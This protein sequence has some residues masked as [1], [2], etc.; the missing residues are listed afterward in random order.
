MLGGG[1]LEE[2]G[3]N[4]LEDWGLPV[5]LAVGSRELGAVS[6]GVPLMKGYFA[7]RV[8]SVVNVSQNGGN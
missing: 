2:E 6:D 5:T 7:V 1:T 3:G 8:R 4:V